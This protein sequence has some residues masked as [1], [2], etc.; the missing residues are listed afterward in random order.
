VTP[1]VAE[2]LAN[3]IGDDSTQLPHQKLS[4][5]EYHTLCLIASGKSLTE[6]GQ[7]MA[8]SVKT[9]SVYRSR[10]LEKM[11]MKHNAELTRYAI[12]NNIVD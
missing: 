8:I 3:S 1:A 9:V 4:I 12:Q 11:H 2:A 6:I 7:Q 5:R 10:I